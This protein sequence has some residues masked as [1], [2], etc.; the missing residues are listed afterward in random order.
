VIPQIEPQAYGDGSQPATLTIPK[1]E[2]P[3]APAASQL[4]APVPNGGSS[5]AEIK[6]FVLK[7]VS[8]KTG[9]PVEMLDLDL[10]LEADLGIDTVKQAE[11]FLTLREHYA[12]TRPED[13]RLS[14]YNTLA[15]VIGFM[16]AGLPA[17][18]QAAHPQPD[19][20]QPA[21]PSAIQPQRVEAASAAP[22]PVTVPDNDDVRQVVLGMVSEKTG[23]PVE[24]L[25]LD[26]DLEADL[27]I[28]TVKQAELF[29]ALRERYAVPRPEDL[30]LS[31]Y[32]TLAKVIHF[33]A[34]PGLAGRGQ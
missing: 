28:D 4:A 11:L 31:D 32:N 2:A 13:L 30:R 5:N 29:M 24:M 27:G 7:E 6:A 34:Q 33:F 21:V 20:K 12:V 25:D 23:Y 1:P 26:L 14:D 3:N 8:E 15:K 10:D 18:S 17:A 9:Y 19:G 16:Q 22:A